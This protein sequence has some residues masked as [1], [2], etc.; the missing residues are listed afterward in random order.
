[1]SGTTEHPLPGEDGYELWLRYP[2]VSDAKLR[3]EYRALLRPANVLGNSP[4]A[5][6]TQRELNYGLG[7]LLERSTDQPNR[8]SGSGLIVVTRAQLSNIAGNVEATGVGET[9]LGPL[10]ALIERELGPSHVPALCE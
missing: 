6:V 8:A 3:A 5:M 4:T 2:P 7:R 1:M 10:R 9:V